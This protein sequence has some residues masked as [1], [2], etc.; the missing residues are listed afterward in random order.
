MTNF[1]KSHVFN[2]ILLGY[3]DST[4]LN[5]VGHVDIMTSLINV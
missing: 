3:F 2:R 4:T 5:N 1:S